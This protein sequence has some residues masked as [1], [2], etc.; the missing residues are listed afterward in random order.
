MSEKS[1]KPELDSVE[2]ILHD[3]KLSEIKK[4]KPI[5]ISNDYVYRVGL[6]SDMH[7]GETTGL[8]PESYETQSG[9][10]VHGSKLQQIL[11][12]QWKRIIEQ[13]NH[14]KVDMIFN[15][16]DTMGGQNPI[17]A[18]GHVLFAEMDDQKLCAEQLLKEVIGNRPNYHF[19]GT[20]YHE[21]RSG[22]HNYHAEIARDLG[23]EFLGPH[24]YLEFQ[25]PTRT[26]R[27]FMA[28]EAPTGLVYPATLMS[29]DISWALASEARGDTLPVD[30]IVR[31][32]IHK[33]L[34]VDHDG[35]HA[36]Q[37]PCWLGHT[38]YKQTIRYYFK[39]QP[40]IGAAMMLID[41]WGR[42]QFWGG[43]FPFSPPAEERTA[44]NLLTMSQLKVN[45]ENKNKV[46]YTKLV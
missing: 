34:H 19:S 3:I 9:Q 2:Q 28:H 6:I 30:A 16:G 42:F 29:R 36:V 35:K 23:G 39:L 17:E 25:C 12:R 31:A 27:V 46:I 40:T 44:I 20:G 13:F 8:F 43:S 14:Y 18:G 38:P 21:V 22:L 15:V 45:A 41:K 10:V 11:Y 33:W 1:Q 32:H 5:R 26:R 24:A 37:L 4:F 7:V